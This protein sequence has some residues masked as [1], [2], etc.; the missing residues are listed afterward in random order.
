MNKVLNFFDRNH[1]IAW[2][3]LA[4]SIPA[5]LYPRFNMQDIAIVR[6]FVGVHNGE[7]T[8]DQQNYLHFVQYFRG[9]VPLDSVH[10]PYSFR[11]LIPFTASLMP[12]SDAMTSINLVNTFSVML[13]VL[14]IILT[15][16]KL[17]YS[18]GIRICGALLYVISFPTLYYSTTGHIDATSTMFLFA[19]IWARISG[20]DIW[21]ILFFILAA[22]AKETSI[23][24][25]PFLFLHLY[26]HNN[27]S[28]RFT[29]SSLFKCLK[30]PAQKE[31]R[32]IYFI[33]W[34]AFILYFVTT[35]IARKAFGMFGDGSDYVWFPSAE[36]LADNIFRSKTYISLIIS[37]GFPGLFALLYISKKHIVKKAVFNAFIIGMC[38]SL[39]MW[40]YSYF[41]AWAD[42]RFI[43]TAYPFMI[44][45]AA[46]YFR[47]RN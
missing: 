36:H 42:G 39:L 38:T 5:I 17:G 6:P 4:I 29:F 9:E 46:E 43:W 18:F 11:P 2:I 8:I 23:I 10:A 44:P 33:F 21:L 25:F 32:N 40:V 1:A 3:I 22:L 16:K 34:I 41:S 12:F 35:I 15:L 24:L 27:P 47:K 14:L 37:F 31:N 26:F 30:I 45:L 19:I 20:E 7:L 28:A 13:T